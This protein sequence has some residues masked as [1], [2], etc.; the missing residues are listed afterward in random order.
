MIW[1]NRLQEQH[2]RVGLAA[3]APPLSFQPPDC[4][5]ACLLCTRQGSPLMRAWPSSSRFLAIDS[6][7]EQ[8]QNLDRPS[9]LTSV[10][11]NSK[12]SQTLSTS[13]YIFNLSQTH[14]P[15]N[16]NFVMETIKSVLG[17]G[18]APQEGR[19]PVSGVTGTGVGGE[20]YDQGNVEGK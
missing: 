19:E 4:N 15:L 14:Y 3:S 18:T 11:F 6:L 20:P 16:H 9:Y 5:D 2:A 12:S 1:K 8:K 17:Y 10:S 13:F 7:H